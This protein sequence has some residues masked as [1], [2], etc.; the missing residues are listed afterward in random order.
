MMWLLMYLPDPLAI[1]TYLLGPGLF[2][3]SIFDAYYW[4]VLL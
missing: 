1:E 4:I 3:L 2:N